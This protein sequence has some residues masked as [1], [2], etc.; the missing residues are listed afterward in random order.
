VKSLDDIQR[1][2]REYEDRKQRFADRDVYSWLNTANLFTI[3]QRQ[4]ALLALLKSHPL[5]DFS[6]LRVLEMGCGSGGV[7]AEWLAFGAAPQNMF[8]VDL[9]Q[10]RL[11]HARQQL[12]ACQFG[13]ADGQFLPFPAQRFD[14]VMQFTAFSSILDGNI[15]QNIAAEMKR[16]V[17]PDGL[18]LWYDFWLN[19]TNPQTRGIR[20]KEVKS[21]FPGCT[22]E[23]HRITLAPPIARRLAPV[24]W[25]LCLF[26][27]SLKVFNT[28]YL[29]A[30]SR[31]H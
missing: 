19:P 16:V 7:L 3:Q 4:R 2:R 26:L 31:K 25:G 5:R 12:P 10:D 14:I 22:Y 9:L 29:V 28:H 23:F 1:L 8:G 17:K 24:S 20:P 27:E 21:L 30:I 6:G 18:L 13:N 15:K 11:C